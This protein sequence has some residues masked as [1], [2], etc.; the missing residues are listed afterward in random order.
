MNPC[1]RCGTPTH[2]SQSLG[3]M[4]WAIC[5]ECMWKEQ[6]QLAQDRWED[7]KHDNEMDRRLELED[8]E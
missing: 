7:A 8:E 4:R 6:D 3:G 5:G 1:P 2:G